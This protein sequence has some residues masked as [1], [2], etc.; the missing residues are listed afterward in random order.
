MNKLSPEVLTLLESI[1]SRRSRRFGL[2][3]EIP[4]GPLAYQ[5]GHAPVSLSEEQ[6]A[7]L[8]YAA[9]GLTGYGLGDLSYGAGEGGNIV[10]SLHGRT[11][12]SGDGIQS[13]SLAVIN[14]AGCHLVKRSRD[15]EMRELKEIIELGNA[16]AVTEVYRRTRVQFANERRSPST[17]PIENININR[18]AAQ[19]PGTS[20]FL[21]INDLTILYINGLLEIFNES[22]GVFAV[23]ERRNFLPAGLGPF[24]RSKGGHLDDDPRLGKMVTIRHI[25]TLVSEFVAIEQGM[26]LQN[27]ALAVDALGLGGYPNFAN[28]E[29]AWFDALGFKMGSMPASRYLGCGLMIRTVLRLMGKDPA[30]PYPLGLEKDGEVLLRAYC[31]PYFSSMSDAVQAVVDL[32]FKQSEGFQPLRWNA[33]LKGPESAAKEV[34]PLS[35]KAIGATKAYCEYVW[36]RYGRFPAHLAPFRT[37]M[38]F[39]VAHLDKDFYDRFYHPGVL[40]EAQRRDFEAVQSGQR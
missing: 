13:V 7:T 24:A 21:P 20:Y 37:I 8:V 35:E 5:S 15:F 4:S 26:M 12:A 25:E 23:D 29:F 28:H 30:V 11:I 31:P 27:M 36:Q 33:S 22:T 40:N 2:G 34:A 10:T 17:D 1:R 39:Q 16:G 6:E 38:G 14:D 9:C 19:A 18:W 32:K 3:M